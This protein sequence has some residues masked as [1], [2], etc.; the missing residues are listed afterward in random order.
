VPPRFESRFRQLARAGET[1]HH[2]S[3]SLASGLR[4]HP[5]RILL[6]IP[7]VDHQGHACLAGKLYVLQK[8]SS[9]FLAG[10]IVVVVVQAALADCNR[11][12]PDKRSDQV[13]VA[14]FIESGCVVRVNARSVPYEARIIRRD[15]MRRASG[16]E[17]VPGAAS[18]ADADDRFGSA[19]LRAAD[20][21]AAVAVERLVCEVR[22]TVDERCATEDFFGHF[23]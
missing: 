1:V 11:A 13:S 9:L 16:A 3:N 8:Y 23:L 10:G 20:Y 19:V 4:H 21:V 5:P 14:H 15:G 17:D 6:G 12:I 18:G 7:G 22:V 2:S